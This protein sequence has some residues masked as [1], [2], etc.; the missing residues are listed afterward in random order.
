MRSEPRKIAVVTGANHG[1][2][3][4]TAAGMAKAGYHVIMACRNRA[5]A[6][7]ARASIMERLPSASLD[8]MVIDL[9]DFASVRAFAKDFRAAYS[10][11]DVLI[12]NAGLLLYSEQANGDG[13]ERQFATNHLGHF[14]LTALLLDLM[15]D[16]PSSR[17]VH[18]SSLAHK[19]A[20]IHFDDL[21]CGGN[22]GRAYGQSKLACLMFGEELH[23]RLQAA[24]LKIRSIPVHP[25]G[26]ASG[27]F[28]EMSRAQYY[29]FKLLSPFILHSNVS[30]ARPSLFAAL[31]AGAEGGRYYGPQGFNEFRGKVGE[32]YRD[33][34]SQGDEE[35]ER[36]WDLSEKL[37]GQPFNPAMPDN[38]P[39]SDAARG[40]KAAT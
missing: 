32:A 7:S 21:T 3:F 26:S 28:E 11:L 39:S 20:Q 29:F 6:E 40:L 30:A 4:E 23:R 35:A 38:V 34:S 37:T 27:L 36:L 22:G 16:D 19:N 8:V 5:K 1:I 14:L 2:G 15:P 10:R 24:G 17:I 31:D 12:N 33:P 18:L 13:I 25:G 9:G